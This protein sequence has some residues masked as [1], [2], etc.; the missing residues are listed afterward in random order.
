[1]GMECYLELP[2]S[3]PYLGKYLR[4]QKPW[5]F[6]KIGPGTG[7]GGKIKNELN[8][9]LHPYGSSYGPK[10]MCCRKKKKIMRRRTMTA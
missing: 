10:K 9:S 6:S 4:R 1:M 2:F 5:P 3:V 7:G 8:Y